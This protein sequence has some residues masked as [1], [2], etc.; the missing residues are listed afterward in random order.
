MPCR[1]LTHKSVSGESL[2]F[3]CE[4]CGIVKDHQEGLRR[5]LRKY[6]TEIDD[7]VQCEVCNKYFHRMD[8]TVSADTWAAPHEKV[9]NGLSQ[10]HTKRRT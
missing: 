8:L 6:H 10:C 9:P 2:R 4:F 7:K 5:H 1:K 3:P